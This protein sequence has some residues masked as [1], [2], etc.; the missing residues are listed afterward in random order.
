MISDALKGVGFPFDGELEI[1]GGEAIGYELTPDGFKPIE[2]V[3]VCPLS[4][5][6]GAEDSKI[7]WH[8]ISEL[9]EEHKDGRW[10]VFESVAGIPEI[11]RGC[12]MGVWIN[13]KGDGGYY[14][15]E[16][17]SKFLELPPLP[18]NKGSQQV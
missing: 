7:K 12:P 18:G 15:E 16:L 13:F 9:R 14:N 2:S 11:L 4:Y 10:M 1:V 3:K 6:K 17:F 5:Q 8:P